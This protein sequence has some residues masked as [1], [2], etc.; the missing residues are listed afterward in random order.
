MSFN[1]SVFLFVHHLAGRS[2]W[3]DGVGVF[4][5]DWLPYLLAAGF[6][7]FVL[8]QKGWRQRFYLF[9]EGALAVIVARGL[10]T[11]TIH[12]LYHEERPFSFYHFAPLVPGIG[13]SFPSAHAAAFFALATML[14]YFNRRWGVWYFAFAVMNGVARVYAGVHWPLDIVGGVAVGVLSAMAVHAALKASRQALEHSVGHAFDNSAV[15]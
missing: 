6:V 1:Q 5:A 4:F 13:W 15:Q 3:I 9:A 10:V 2:G 14:W 11:E 8:G 7:V 12:L